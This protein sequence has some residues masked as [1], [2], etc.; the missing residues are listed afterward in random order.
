MRAPELGRAPRP[1]RRRRP[2]RLL[3]GAR[4]RRSLA[5]AWLAPPSRCARL[6]TA[7]ARRPAH[8]AARSPSRR[9]PV[10]ARRRW[11]RWSALAAAAPWRRRRG[12]GRRAAA[13]GC[14]SRCSTSARA[15]R[16]CCSR[17]GAPAVLVDGGPPGDD[18]AAKLARPASSGSAPRSSP[19]TS[20]TTPA[21]SRSCSARFPVAR[22]VYARL[23]RAT[24][25]RGPRRRRAT[26]CGSPRGGELRSGGL[27]LEV[28]WPPPELL[29]EPAPRRRP[30]P[31]GAGPARPLAR[32]LDAAHR[33]RRGG[34]GAARPRPG[35]RAQGRPPRQRRRR[36]R[37]RCSTAPGRGSR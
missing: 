37:G 33:R 24:A 13:P 9:R 15:T 30:E 2:G 7:H 23:G 32:L 10:A 3:P 31:A 18:L 29:G 34:G 17:A 36:P 19:T 1:P 14:G 21:A 22:L 20:P 5:C 26:P 12:R 28:L 6:A 27:R 11:R 8:P 35:R 4:R 25:G 16:S